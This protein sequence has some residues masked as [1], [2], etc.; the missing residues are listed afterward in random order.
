MKASKHL[1]VII[2]YVF[3][4]SD[5]KTIKLFDLNTYECIRAFIGHEDRVHSIDTKLNDGKLLVGQ[6]N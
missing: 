6:N 4:W 2:S 3:L 5:D 1:L